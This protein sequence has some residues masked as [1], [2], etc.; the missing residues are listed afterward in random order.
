[1]DTLSASISTSQLLPRKL[2]VWSMCTGL[3]GFSG[4]IQGWLA[5]FGG[6]FWC[7]AQSCA[8]MAEVHDLYLGPQT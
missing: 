2:M 4:S 1:M 7:S 5:T 6:L 3:H 8:S